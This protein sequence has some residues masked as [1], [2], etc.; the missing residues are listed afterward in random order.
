MNFVETNNNN[1]YSLKSCLK[2]GKLPLKMANLSEW[3]T[4]ETFIDFKQQTFNL[5][6]SF[7]HLIEHPIDCCNHQHQ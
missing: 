2:C 6:F 4:K 3:Q 1:N 5:I 7:L